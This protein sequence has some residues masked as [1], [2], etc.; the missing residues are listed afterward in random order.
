VLSVH[1]TVGRRDHIVEAGVAEPRYT[2]LIG[3]NWIVDSN[4][5]TLR[6]VQATLG[7]TFRIS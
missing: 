6:R 1:G 2:L 4:V 3:P 7:G 5:K